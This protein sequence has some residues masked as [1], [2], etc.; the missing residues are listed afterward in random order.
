[1]A[2]YLPKYKTNEKTTSYDQIDHQSRSDDVLNSCESISSE[3]NIPPIFVE[4]NRDAE[5][6]PVLARFDHFFSA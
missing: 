1:M 5:L 3:L 6:E 4:E 2:S